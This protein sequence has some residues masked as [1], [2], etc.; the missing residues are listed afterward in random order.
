MLVALAWAVVSVLRLPPRAELVFQTVREGDRAAL[1]AFVRAEPG[2]VGWRDSLGY[3]PLHWAAATSDDGE[4][5]LLLGAGADPNARNHRGQTPLHVAAMSQ[6][7]CGDALMKSLIA[8]GADVNAADEGGV[9]PLE[10]AQRMD[11]SDLS[12]TLLAAGAAAPQGAPDAP[13]RRIADGP[14]W[15]RAA[16]DRPMF[17]ARRWVRRGMGPRRAWIRLHGWRPQPAAMHGEG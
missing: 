13:D 3:T 4:V 15:R 5:R 10:F 8:G 12:Q 7:R 6:I 2:V 9:T 17:A 14:G 16:A 1:A 11:R